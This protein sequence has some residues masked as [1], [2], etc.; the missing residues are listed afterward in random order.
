MA[1]ESYTYPHFGIYSTPFLQIWFREMKYGQYN[2]M[3]SVEPQF[4]FAAE[5]AIKPWGLPS[6]AALDDPKRPRRVLVYARSH[7]ER[8]AYQLTIDSLSV[9][10]C[11][12]YFDGDLS[13]Q[14]I[15]VGSV[16]DDVEILGSMCGRRMEMTI[17]KNVP[18]NQ[19]RQLVQLG[20]VGLSLMVSPHPSLPPF[21]FVAA[22]LVTVTNSFGTKTPKRLTKV[23]GHI[24]M[25]S[26][27]GG[28]PPL[29]LQI[30]L[31]QT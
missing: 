7:A 4:S 8:N 16:R 3:D 10:V 27:Q 31:N 2:Y 19:Y 28:P 1:L 25:K 22:G 24:R 6:K 15:G 17:L 5:P 11:K 9:A 26:L 20:D 30:A 18:E 21:D 29:P 12:G 14:I 23:H 13:W